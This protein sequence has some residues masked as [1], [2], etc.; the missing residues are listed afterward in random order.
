MVNHNIHRIE[1]PRIRPM[2]PKNIRSECALQRG[3]AKH[4]SGIT[5]QNKLHKPVTKP[6]DAVVKK[7]RMRHDKNDIDDSSILKLKTP[8]LSSYDKKLEAHR[9]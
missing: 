5:P 2:S 1:I 8:T 4:R 3:K 6:A 9:F 7:D